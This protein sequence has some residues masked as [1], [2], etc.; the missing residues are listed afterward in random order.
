MGREGGGMERVRKLERS[1]ITKRI[2][3]PEILQWQL[4]ISSPLR[5]YYSYLK[6]LVILL[7]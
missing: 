6:M 4:L 5:F 2:A 3:C 7:C 1:T